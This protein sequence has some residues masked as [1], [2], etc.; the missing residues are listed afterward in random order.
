MVNEVKT[1]HGMGPGGNFYI[2]EYHQII[3]PVAGRTGEYYLAGEYREPLRFEFE[4]RV[5]SGEPIDLEQRPLSIGSVW[6]GS[7]G[8]S[9]HIGRRWKRHLL[10]ILAPAAGREENQTQPDNRSGDGSCI[11]TPDQGDKGACWWSLLRQ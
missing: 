9:L 5:I 6:V 2:N 3:V 11:R 1:T 10:H 7:C 4:G 8:H